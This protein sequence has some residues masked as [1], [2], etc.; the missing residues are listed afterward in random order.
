MNHHTVTPAIQKLCQ[1]LDDDLG[2][3]LNDIE[4]TAN[5]SLNSNNSTSISQLAEIINEDFKHF[6]ENLQSNLKIF[7]ENLCKSMANII[8]EL[9]E[10][11]KNDET[12][13]DLNIKKI[14]LICR[15]SNSL[16]NFCPNLKLCFNN[17][18]HQQIAHRQLI[19]KTSNSNDLLSSPQLNSI[20]KKKAIADQKVNNLNKT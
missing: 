9:N 15:F 20:I 7:S 16:T 17:L 10:D 19:A 3:L 5:I 14:L 4:F 6:N 8:N 11:C 2:H 1:V 13:N 18:N 12:K